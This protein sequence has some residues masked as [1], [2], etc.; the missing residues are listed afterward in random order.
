MSPK[1]VCFGSAK[2]G[3]G[4]TVITATIGAFLSALGKRVLLVDAD[5]ATNGLTLLYIKEVLSK[6]GK[7][8]DESPEGLFEGNSQGEPSAFPLPSGVSLIP[9]T[10][11][12][13]NTENY[14]QEHF[15]GRVAGR[16]KTANVTSIS[17]C[18]M[19]KPVRTSV[20]ASQ[21]AKEFRM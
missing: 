14:Q 20:R 5:A 7:T 18:S 9:A 10:Y 21:C 17:F 3:S 6:Q 1:V 2:G 8:S 19:R 15:V 12:F 13:T 11:N 16:L 4:K